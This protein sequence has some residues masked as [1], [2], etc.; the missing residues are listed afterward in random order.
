[1]E[2]VLRRLGEQEKAVAPVGTTVVQAE[3]LLR[4]LEL[5]DTQ[6]QVRNPANAPKSVTWDLWTEGVCWS[7]RRRWLVRRW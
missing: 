2:E 5:L 6:A 4:D 3:Q 7:A 1:M